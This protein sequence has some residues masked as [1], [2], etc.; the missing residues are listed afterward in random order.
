MWTIT[1]VPAPCFKCKADCKERFIKV[2]NIE[3]GY[4]FMFKF[5]L[6]ILKCFKPQSDFWVTFFIDELYADFNTYQ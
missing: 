6:G 5:K 3:L 4:S 2:G 1:G